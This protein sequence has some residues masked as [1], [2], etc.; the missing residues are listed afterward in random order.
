METKRTKAFGFVRNI[1]LRWSGSG[2]GS[3]D[4]VPKKVE[5]FKTLGYTR[6]K[7]YHKAYWFTK[8]KNLNGALECRVL[9]ENLQENKAKSDLGSGNIYIYI[10]IYIYMYIYIYIYNSTH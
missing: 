5:C 3:R 2:S 7:L 1:T 8:K 4:T 6:R 10:Y 9:T